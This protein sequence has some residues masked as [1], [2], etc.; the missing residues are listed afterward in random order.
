M[1]VFLGLKIP[2]LWTHNRPRVLTNGPGSL[3]DLP[4]VGGR[5]PVGV[6]VVVGDGH[7][8]QPVVLRGKRARVGQAVGLV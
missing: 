5:V 2:N 7:V 3:P 6:T 4:M 1:E 8:V